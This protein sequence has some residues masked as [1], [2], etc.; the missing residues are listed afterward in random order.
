ME[1][2]FN[3]NQVIPTIDKRSRCSNLYQDFLKQCRVHL[4]YVT[5][6]CGQFFSIFLFVLIN[7]YIEK[8]ASCVWWKM[9]FIVSRWRRKVS[10][11]YKNETLSVLSQLENITNPE[12]RLLSNV[13]FRLTILFSS[14]YPQDYKKGSYFKRIILTFIWRIITTY[15]HIYLLLLPFQKF[16]G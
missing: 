16:F 4:M 7:T 15:H 1:K 14:S 9:S 3:P 13:L 6:R 5:S 8:R 10:G 12:F 2:D 11:S